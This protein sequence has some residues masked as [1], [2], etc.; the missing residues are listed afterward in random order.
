MNIY[1]GLLFLHGFRVLP[2][3][4][5]ASR[6]TVDGCCG[7]GTPTPPAR[8]VP[9]ARGDASPLVGTTA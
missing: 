7:A 9:P 5:T 1:Q 2:D 8:L 3:E 4:A 6:A